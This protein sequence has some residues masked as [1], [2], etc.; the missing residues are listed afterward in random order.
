M[1]LRISALGLATLALGTSVTV[2]SAQTTAPPH[3]VIPAAATGP[4]HRFFG[5]LQSVDGHLLTIQLRNGRLLR[6]DAARAFTAKRVSEP[7]FPGKPTVVD[8]TLGAGGVFIATTVKR[9]APL[10]TNWGLDQ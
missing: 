10:A 5:T 2:A 4:Q 3:H 9:G 8:G 1:N 6:V 7:L